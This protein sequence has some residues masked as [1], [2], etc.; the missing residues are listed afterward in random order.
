MGRKPIKFHVSPAA[1]RADSCGHNVPE[2]PERGG[3][4]DAGDESL[5]FLLM[6]LAVAEASPR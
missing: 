3:G 4:A 6:L 5:L 1:I 2:P